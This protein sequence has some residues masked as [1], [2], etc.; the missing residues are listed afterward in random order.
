MQFFF[1]FTA[2]GVSVG[3][4]KVMGAFLHSYPGMAITRTTNWLA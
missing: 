3:G 4:W 2:L 1:D